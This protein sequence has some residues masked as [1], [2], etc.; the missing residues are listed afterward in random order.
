MVGSWRGKRKNIRKI[1]INTGVKNEI[2]PRGFIPGD[3]KHIIPWDFRESS[4]LVQR[5]AKS[6]DAFH[7]NE[8]LN[9][10]PLPSTNHLTG[11]HL[12]NAKVLE[13]VE[14]LETIATN[15]DHAYTLL[16]G[17]IQHIDN[18]IKNNPGLNLGQISDLISYP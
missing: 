11:H 3:G 9:G 5:A 15:N 12:Y 6:K 2:K 16:T 1:R 13:V 14:D 8:A 18:L 17:L 4:E 7:I 10:V